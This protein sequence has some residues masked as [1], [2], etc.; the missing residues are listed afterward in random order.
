MTK[1]FL[2]FVQY[3]QGGR[4]F[5]YVITLDAQWR[6][7]ETGKEFGIGLLSKHTMH[8]DVSIY[9]AFSGEFFIR[10]LKHL[11]MEKEESSDKPGANIEPAEADHHDEHE[12]PGSSLKSTDPRN[13]EL[14]VDND[15]GTY[16]PNA[17]YLPELKEFMSANLPGLRVRILDCQ[18]DE[19]KM[20]KLKDEQ[21]ARKK[22][23]GK[24]ITNQQNSS[25]SSFSSGDVR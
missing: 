20:N 5:T 14:I 25:S 2:K 23:S 10:R 9:I 22:G 11:K 19:E 16:R 24:Q 21:R 17:K 18:K 8:S 4:I 12:Q 6:F 3:D 13:F 1:Q 15:S 7:T